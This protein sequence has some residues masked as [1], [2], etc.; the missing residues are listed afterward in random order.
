M[1]PAAP[2]WPARTIACSLHL[3][4][5]LPAG[6]PSELL[7]CVHGGGYTRAYWHPR[8]PDFPGYSFAEHVCAR[9][10]AVLAIDLLG[11]G[12]STKPEPETLLSREIVACRQPPGHHRDYAGPA[13]WP[14]GQGGAHND[15]RHRPFDR[16]H[17]GDH[18]AS[19]PSIIRSSCRSGLGK[20][21][22]GAGGPRSSGARRIDRARLP[23][24]ATR[25]DAPVVLR[26]GCAESLD[27]GR[28]GGRF[29]HAGLPRPRR[30]SSRHRP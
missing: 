19:H 27:R 30:P 25:A 29:N 22:S 17:D 15:H 18:A 28:R 10:R 5:D 26:A 4:D 21:A 13:R 23:G 9:N 14:M 3:P 1:L 7:I 6:A 12:E 20:P 11:M 16:R 8:F 24:V 2:A